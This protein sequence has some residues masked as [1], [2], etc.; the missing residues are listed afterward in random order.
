LL[1]ASTL[2]FVTSVASA[3]VAAIPA[4]TEVVIRT[5]E[6]INAREADEGHEYAAVL[7]EPLIVDG[8]V[9]AAKGAEATLQVVEATRAT[10]VRGRASL[11]LQLTAVAIGGRRVA[12]VT[13]GVKSEG[14]SQAG[15][16]AKAGVGGAAVGALVGGLLGGAS[17]AAKGAAVGGG[18]GVG[19]VAVTGQRI[20]VPA[21]TRLTFVLANQAP[22]RP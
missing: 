4:D 7:D 17:G 6:P 22:L 12:V 15:R 19:V 21:E 20:Q 5:A 16:A 11:T 14:G 10:G 13:Q 1:L 18:A 8:N 3:Q 9:L 2:V